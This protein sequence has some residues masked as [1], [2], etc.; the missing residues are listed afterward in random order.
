[1]P[2]ETHGRWP[3]IAAALVA[4]AWG[5]ALA[6]RGAL[7]RDDAWVAALGLPILVTHQTE[8]WVRPGGFLPFCN[9]RLL[10]SDR[11]TW[12]LTERDAFHVNV[13]AGW[14]TAILA[15]ALWRR[16][17]AP[18]AVV[19][20]AEAGNTAMHAGMALRERRYNPG[21][22]TGVALMGVHAA[23]GARTIRR[24]GRLG[25]AEALGA[26]VLGIGL[27]AFL[28]VAMKRRMRRTAGRD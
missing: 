12:P 19:L 16:S 26:A 15:A 10:R 4:P 27:S 18:A 21:L 13:T 22:V 28:P 9:E 14:G 8:E 6:W 7:G 24:S 20:W 25:R 2:I 3:W 1:M 11:P 5:A 23:A 17:A